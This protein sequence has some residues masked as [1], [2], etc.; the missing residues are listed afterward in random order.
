MPELKNLKHE[1]FCHLIVQGNVPAAA[2]VG[3]GF[4]TSTKHSAEASGHRLL[5]S[6]EVA[7]RIAELRLPVTQDL[8]LTTT[9][10][11]DR[12]RAIGLGDTGKLLRWSDKGVKLADSDKLTADQRAMVADIRVVDGAVSLKLRD[13]APALRLLGAHMGLFSGEVGAT[14]ATRR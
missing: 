10:I 3:A 14:R 7:T 8:Q 5:K 6:V 4:S 2:Y 1:K 13:P 11:L 9:M 12:L